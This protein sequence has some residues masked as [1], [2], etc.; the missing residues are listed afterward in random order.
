MMSDPSEWPPERQH[1]DALTVREVCA[2]ITRLRQTNESMR[3]VIDRSLAH[4]REM[5][6]FLQTLEPEPVKPTIYV[7]GR[8]VCCGVPMW[9]TMVQ[10][11][12]DLRCGDYKCQVCG[13]TI[14]ETEGPATSTV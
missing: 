9:L 2:E 13:K 3:L 14:G 7:D 8:P 11:S 10:I 5:Y 6:A 4:L 12:A 1:V